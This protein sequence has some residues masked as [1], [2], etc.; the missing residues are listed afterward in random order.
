MYVWCDALTNYISAIGYGRDEDLFAQWWGSEEVVHVIGKDILRFHAAI[1]PGMLLAAGIALPKKIIVHGFITV[2]G[3]KMSKTVG[4]VLDPVELVEKYGI[5]P[6]R[7][8][9]LREIPSGEDGDFSIKK[10]EERYNGDLANGIGNLVA[11]VSTIGEKISPLSFVWPE[12][13][14]P[15]NDIDDIKKEVDFIKLQYEGYMSG[16]NGLRFDQALM[17]VWKIISL[18][19]RYINETKPWSIKDDPER[20]KEIISTASHL[21]AIV[22]DLLLPF[23]PETAVKIKEQISIEGDNIKI[24]RGNALFPRLLI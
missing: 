6:V 15:A 3:E 11:R 22:A 20:L 8:Y 17:E 21:I 5:D 13:L 18:G 4:N 23:L 1:W 7:Y 14:A 10:F 19:D 12:V 9:L 16:G 24:K 2:E